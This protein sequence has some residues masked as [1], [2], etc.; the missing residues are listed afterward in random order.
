MTIRQ[1]L[2]PVDRV[3]FVYLLYVPVLVMLFA[4]ELADYT[5]IFVGNSLVAL[6]VWLLARYATPGTAFA[7]DFLRGIY[8]ALLFTYFYNQTGS[9]MNLIHAEFFDSWFTQWEFTTYGFNATLW[10][11]SNVLTGAW[12]KWLTESLSLAYFSYYLMFPAMLI[13]LLIK[14]RNELVGEYMTASA[15]VFFVSYNLFWFFPLEGPRWHFAEVYQFSVDGPFFREMV[16][17]VIAGGAV[18]GGCMP[19]T[20]TGVALVTLMFLWRDF[21]TAFWISLPFGLGIALGAVYG[22]FHYPTD[23]V[24]G[25]LIAAPLTWYTMRNYSRWR[26]RSSHAPVES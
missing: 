13:T 19:S 17:Y 1:Y 8:P 2:Q 23:I 18:R 22:R 24:V 9:L 26:S 25:A 12:V 21:R 16:N 6:F 10:L 11:E 4:T 14:K 7:L 3:V 20:H 15:I 5:H